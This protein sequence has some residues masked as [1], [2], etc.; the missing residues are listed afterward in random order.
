[1][2]GLMG[3]A[4]MAG[5]PGGAFSPLSLFAA[6]EQ[7]AWYDPSDFSSMFQDSAGTTPVTA[8]EQPVGRINDKS[9]NGNHATQA[10]AAARPVVS[11]RVNLLTYSEDLSN[12]AWV[13]L[14]GATITGT[15]LLNLPSEVDS[16]YNLC[17]FKPNTPAKVQLRLSGS[18]TVSLNL[19]DAGFSSQIQVTL[20]STPTVYTHGMTSHPLCTH[21]F[22]QIIRAVG[23]TATSVTVTDV[24]MEVG[25]AATRYQRVTTA[26]DYDSAGF[27]QYIANDGIDDLL[28]T[29]FPNLGSAC[30]IA[31]AVP[32]V[33]AS[34]LT[35][36]TIGA[37]VR[38][39]ATNH[40]GLVI[41]DRA[42]TAGET[43]ALTAYLNAKAGV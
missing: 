27:P 42:L 33:G 30:T 38:N 39:D 16:A 40:A 43:T 1:M 5:Q 24:Q 37:G 26:S 14:A 9:G 4:R 12:A 28:A 22:I 31:R 36:Q 8:V 19:F 17:V 3:V 18:G 29:T 41:I 35:G 32:G 15:N 11:A 21:M 6:S 25:T 2:F 13:K 10:T 34:I 23:D 7:G 20:T